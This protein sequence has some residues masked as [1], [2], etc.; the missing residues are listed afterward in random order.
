MTSQNLY[1]SATVDEA[2]HTL[3][4]AC[5]VAKEAF[6]DGLLVEEEFLATIDDLKANFR[7]QMQENGE[8]SEKQLLQ[9]ENEAIAQPPLRPTSFMRDDASSVRS[10]GGF[11][12]NDAGH[13]PMSLPEPGLGGQSTR[14]A[15]HNHNQSLPFNAQDQYKRPKSGS[16][17]KQSGHADHTSHAMTPL[18]WSENFQDAQDDRAHVEVTV[19]TEREGGE[20]Q[21]LEG[22]SSSPPSGPPVSHPASPSP[23][24][25]PAR[26]NQNISFCCPSATPAP[27][28]ISSNGLLNEVR[29]N[30]TVVQAAVVSTP[31]VLASC[32]LTAAVV[33]LC[34]KLDVQAAAVAASILLVI[35]SLVLTRLA[36]IPQE[37]PMCMLLCAASNLLGGMA[38]G[39]VLLSLTRSLHLSCELRQADFQG[40]EVAACPSLAE[41]LSSSSGDGDCDREQ[42]GDSGCDCEAPPIE[43]CKAHVLY[44]AYILALVDVCHGVL[45]ALLVVLVI[46]RVEVGNWSK[47]QFQSFDVDHRITHSVVTNNEERDLEA[48]FANRL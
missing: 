38:G 33:V 42:L 14:K 25:A 9:M 45:L 31:G 30:E 5:Q 15:I 4:V 13:G 23:N 35:A 34:S 7:S 43:N 21:R 8:W 37:P 28:R 10:L 20:G 39:L 27:P 40:C 3:Q 22:G 11:E 2:K 26:P 29:H 12:S 32:G 19:D 24:S 46:V 48:E 44:A 36:R 6:E 41:C 16:K 17:E 1:P 18:S 47:T